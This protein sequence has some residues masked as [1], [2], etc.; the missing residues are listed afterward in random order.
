[1]LLNPFYI[2]IFL[3][4]GLLFFYC[5]APKPSIILEYPNMKEHFSEIDGQKY[6]YIYTYDN[7]K[8]VNNN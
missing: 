6:K 5:T 8:I 2:L 3:Y 7:I 4:I 1:M